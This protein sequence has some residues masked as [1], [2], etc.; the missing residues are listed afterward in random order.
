[1]SFP[2]GRTRRYSIT[3]LTLGYSH[4]NH[5]YI[6]PFLDI[7]FSILQR[8]LPMNG[9]CWNIRTFLLFH[10]LH[11]IQKGKSCWCFNLIDVQ[12][13]KQASIFSSNETLEFKI[14]WQ[15]I[16]DALHTACAYWHSK[17]YICISVSSAIQHRLHCASLVTCLLFK[18]V[19]V[20]KL[21]DCSL[22]ANVSV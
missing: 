7:I 3:A 9:F 22:Q 21:S 4:R 8:S 5:I 15:G 12:Q 13:C 6:I 19:P 20:A 11:S 16:P 17:K 2:I 18:L 14:I 1:M 10:N